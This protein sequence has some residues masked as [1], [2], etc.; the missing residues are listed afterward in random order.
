MALSIL[1]V[2]IDLT[3]N[4]LLL[5]SLA[6]RRPIAQRAV[7]EAEIQHAPIRA[8]RGNRIGGG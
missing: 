8:R 2:L 6:R 5:K 1:P 3:L 4:R 7:L